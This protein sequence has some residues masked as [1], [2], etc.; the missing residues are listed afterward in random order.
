MDSPSRNAA[1]RGDL[2]YAT[3]KICAAE[4]QR[5]GFTIGRES[6]AVLTHAVLGWVPML[7]KDLEAFAAHASRTTVGPADV[8]LVA[9]RS[10]TTLEALEALDRDHIADRG[11]RSRSRKKR[12]VAAA[13]EE[14][15][16]VVEEEEEEAEARGPRGGGGGG[17]FMTA[18]AAA[19]PAAAA[20]SAAA[21]AASPAA[22]RSPP[23]R[24]SGVGQLSSS[25]DEGDSLDLT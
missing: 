8:K 22:S 17:G 6:V 24:A 21:A 13:A 16:E 9:R 14:V 25:S 10:E 5:D 4:A 18:A 3:K 19:A 20:A 23:A 12:R 7:A 15:V 2:M 1:V 11:A